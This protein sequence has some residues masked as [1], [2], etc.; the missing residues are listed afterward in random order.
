[1]TRTRLFIILGFALA[2]VAGGSVGMLTAPG[3]RDGRTQHP[4]GPDRLSKELGLSSEQQAQMRDIWSK[5]MGGEAM[6]QWRQRRQEL[7]RQ[8]T[9]AIEALLSDQQRKQY[10]QI[11]AEHA[12]RI[13]E[14]EQERHQLVQAAVDR[15]KSI[16]TPEQAK[17]YEEI[18]K[19][20]RRGPS[21]GPGADRR[22]GGY[23][24][25]F[26]RGRQR[27]DSQ[28]ASRPAREQ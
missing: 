25:R 16:L 14:Y 12:R 23:G 27:P 24:E 5:V 10:E 17:K 7:G 28:P 4:R 21:S 26:R 13:E 18:R 19:S 22:F 6:Q 2:F 11:L 1:M 8:R 20:Q 3:Q 15:T 9:E